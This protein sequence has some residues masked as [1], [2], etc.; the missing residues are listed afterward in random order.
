MRQHEGLECLNKTKQ[1]GL[2]FQNYAFTFNNTFPPSASLTKAADGTQTVGGWSHLVR[3]L[4]FF[5]YDTYKD[6]VDQYGPGRHF[7]RR[8]SLG[9]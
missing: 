3:L 2:N 5:Q 8:E 6:L 4:P 7:E 1:I 9:R